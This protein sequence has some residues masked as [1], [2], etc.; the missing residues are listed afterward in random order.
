MLTAAAAKWSGKSAWEDRFF[1]VKWPDWPALDRW[2]LAQEPV[3]IVE[4][5]AAATNS[6]CRM[7]PGC[8]YLVSDANSPIA[9]LGV[10]ETRCV[11]S[12]ALSNLL[13]GNVHVLQITPKPWPTLQQLSLSACRSSEEGALHCT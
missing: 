4:Q 2:T 6:A 7:Q 13:G 9:F 10:R 11:I 1:L 12:E 3:G 5:W 8:E